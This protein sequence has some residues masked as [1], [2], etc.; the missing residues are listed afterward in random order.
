MSAGASAAAETISPSRLR[1][2]QIVETRGK[3]LIC[4]QVVGDRLRAGV[5]ALTLELCAQLNDR[6]DGPGESA[7][8]QER[9]LRERGSSAS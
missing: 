2:R 8:G 9:G 6:L 4:L 7:R 1:M 3:S 5:M